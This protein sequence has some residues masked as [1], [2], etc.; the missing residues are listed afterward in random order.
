MSRSYFTDLTEPQWLQL[1]DAIVPATAREIVNGILY[2]E[3][4]CQ[5]WWLTPDTFPPASILQDCY[6]RWQRDGTWDRIREIVPRTNQTR[7]AKEDNVLRRISRI[8]KTLPG[9][10][11]ILAAGR[12]PIQVAQ[13]FQRLGSPHHWWLWRLL[14]TI[15]TGDRRLARKDYNAA[16]RAFDVALEMAPWHA[17]PRL[18]RAH[19]LYQLNRYDEVVRECSLALSAPV[20]NIRIRHEA[21][22]LIAR[23][24]ALKGGDPSRAA[25]H[26]TESWWANDNARDGTRDGFGPL[27]KLDGLM[28][29][30]DALAEYAINDHMAF[31]VA[32]TLYRNKPVERKALLE[33]SANAHGL[34]QVREYVN[35]KGLIL[36]TDWVRN[37]G[38]TAYL[39]TIAKMQ[40]LGWEPRTRMTLLAPPHATANLHYAHYWCRHFQVITDTKLVESLEPFARSFGPR[41]ASRIVLPDGREHYFL[42]ALGIVQEAWEV[43]NRPPLLELT[44]EDQEYR[45]RLL[46]LLGLSDDAWFVCLHV[47][48]PGF[49]KEK[50]N[51]HQSHRNA[52]I[53]TYLSAIRDITSRGGWVIRMGDPTMSR[54][55]KMTN[56]IDFAHS[57]HK[58]PRADIVF[59][60][61]CRFFLGV[62]SGLCQIPTTFG[63]PCVLTNWIS[64]ALPLYSRDDVFIPKLL[65]CQKT[66]RVL[67]FKEMYSPTPR[68][69]AYSGVFLLKHNLE[70][71]DNTEDEL[72]AVVVEMLDR[73]AG[74]ENRTRQDEQNQ[75]HI[76]SLIR[77]AGVNGFA[78][79]GRD[80]LRRHADLLRVQERT[81]SSAAA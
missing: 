14:W 7:E 66:R 29:A 63:R 41:V 46:K 40:I 72:H 21:H 6:D 26:L 50:G 32:M 52:D 20:T 55:P 37:I 10:E 35:A 67:S 71:V 13:V 49:H 77:S 4:A 65:R 28:T 54:L 58:S 3:R 76:R 39:D 27:T 24:L 2:F 19:A 74:R 36:S 5:I 68:Q 70:A 23:S 64:N 79:L 9:S 45:K 31:P 15:G 73:L 33:C 48:E 16:I 1:Q 38:H 18:G 57:P 12:F 78:R 51:I 22:A 81:A 8:V 75:I 42:E 62:A 61:S 47:R 11:A 43:E 53:H 59:C 25:R 44:S 56:V 34:M 60:A 69:A 17:H 30:H 80:F